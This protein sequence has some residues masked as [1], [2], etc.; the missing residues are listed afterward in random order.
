MNDLIRTGTSFSRQAA[1]IQQPETECGHKLT[2]VMLRS[3]LVKCL[4][5]KSSTKKLSNLNG[6]DIS[7]TYCNVPGDGSPAKAALTNTQLHVLD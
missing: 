5:T 1:N 2:N 4:L 6:T 3:I 7:N